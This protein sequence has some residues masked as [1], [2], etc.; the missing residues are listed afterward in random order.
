MSSYL[1]KH[2][3]M[4]CFL[5]IL[6][7]F[8]L[9]SCKTADSSGGGGQ[10]EEEQYVSEC[11][12]EDENGIYVSVSGSDES[13]GTFDEP[14][15]TITKALSLSQPGQTIYVKSGVYDEQ[16]SFPTAGESDSRIT[17]RSCG[18]DTVSLTH[19]R[20]LGA[21]LVDIGKAYI[22]MENF[23]IDGQWREADIVKIRDQGNYAI[24][25]N[26]EIKNTK[27]DGVDMD[28][29]VGVLIDCCIIH[30]ALRFNESSNERD[31][32]HGIVTAGVQDLIIRDTEIYY[33]SGDTLQFQYNAWDNILVEN[34]ALWNG[35]LP[36][37]RAGFPAGVNPGENAVDTKYYTSHGRGRLYMK[38][39]IAYGWD[40][41]YLANGAAFNIKH[42]VEA[43][44][45]GITTYDNDIAFRLRGPAS[46]STGGAWVTMK[47]VVIY[48][49]KRAVRY[50]DDIENLK[51][52]HTTF[53][54]GNGSLFQSAGGYGDGFEVKNNLFL[55]TKPTEATDSSNLAVD[56]SSFDDADSHDYHLAASSIA[57]DNADSSINVTADRDGFSRPYSENPDVGAYEYH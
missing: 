7:T 42:N 28:D 32:A 35:K 54:N 43:V 34:C 11:T 20:N 51:I 29:P 23:I 5:F 25:R 6:L 49:T 38:N 31:D 14:Y 15:A 53:G 33:V 3:I 24:L 45:D 41:D 56:D 55:G 4:L 44:L 37:A 36:E 1:I 39:I 21:Y 17:L 12:G 47:N 57:I 2:H 46:I 30:D 52:Y 26:L 13:P 40:S 22:T 50:E 16:I 8:G 18:D 27:R 10:D 19:S 9:M 48:N